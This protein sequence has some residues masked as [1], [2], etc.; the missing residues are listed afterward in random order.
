MRALLAELWL[1]HSDRSG[2]PSGVVKHCWLGNP[3]Q[4][5]ISMEKSF[6]MIKM[7]IYH[8][9]IE[10]SSVKLPTSNVACTNAIF[11]Q[12]LLIALQPTWSQQ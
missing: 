10:G 4:V 8:P 11:I 5:G 6:N 9:V 2:L 3:L 1:L 7:E 12:D